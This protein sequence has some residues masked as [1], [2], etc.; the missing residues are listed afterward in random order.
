[1]DDELNDADE[2][3]RL[4]DAAL[5]LVCEDNRRYRVERCVE[6]EACSCPLSSLVAAL[7]GETVEPPRLVPL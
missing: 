2:L 6:R 4:V 5:A 3:K 7:C 1:M